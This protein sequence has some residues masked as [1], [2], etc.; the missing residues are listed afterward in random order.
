MLGP[1]GSYHRRLRLGAA[2]FLVDLSDKLQARLPALS[3]QLPAGGERGNPSPL[4]A[5]ETS[6]GA[7]PANGEQGSWQVLM[8][9]VSAPRTLP[10]FPHCRELLGLVRE[11]L[12]YHI[13][14]K[15]LLVEERDK[16]IPVCC[17]RHSHI[18]SAVLAGES[19]R[20]I[21]YCNG[22]INARERASR[23]NK[24]RRKKGAR[25]CTSITGRG[26]PGRNEKKRG[27]R[28]HVK[29]SRAYALGL[30]SSLATVS[31]GCS[32]SLASKVPRSCK[33]VRAPVE[34]G[35]FCQPEPSRSLTGL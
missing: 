12:A 6:R 1:R 22:M 8:R 9:Q 29:E 4:P 2:T 24:K 10:S 34:G 33:P 35:P 23:R 18:K 30:H 27:V 3:R 20:R 15:G 26:D 11:C 25:I 5:L 28:R 14:L 17:T 13:I 32:E 16:K 7:R 31:S 19:R 21:R